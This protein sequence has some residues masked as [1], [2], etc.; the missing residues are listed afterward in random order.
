[1]ICLRLVEGQA[2]VQEAQKPLPFGPG[3]TDGLDRI[4]RVEIWGTTWDD[5]EDFTE[6]RVYAGDECRATV[7]V[8][9]Y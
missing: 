3:L 6:F 8:A 4:T 1:M 9:G 7:R 5:G 2:A